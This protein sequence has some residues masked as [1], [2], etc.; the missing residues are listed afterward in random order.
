M[1]SAGGAEHLDFGKGS[2]VEVSSDDEGF[3]DSWYVATVLDVPSKK[4]RRKRE[5]EK[6]TRQNK[7]MYLVEYET[8]LANDD[9][10]ELLREYVDLSFIRPLPPTDDGDGQQTSLEVND[11][12]D[13]FHR[14]G[15]WTGVITRSVINVDHNQESRFVVL[16]Q[17]PLDEV[18]FARSELRVHHD[19]ING[20]WVRPEKQVSEQSKVVLQSNQ[21][22]LSKI[23]RRPK[24]Q[25]KS[26]RGSAM[27]FQC[28]RRGKTYGV[29][30]ANC[31]S[32]DAE[33][34]S[35]EMSVDDRPLLMW[36]KGKDCPTTLVDSR[37]FLGKAVNQLAE[38]S[39]RPNE[40][41]MQSPAISYTA[42]VSKKNTKLPF[43]KCSPIW[44]VVADMEVFKKIPQEPHFCPLYEAKVDNREGLAI[45]M[46]VT[47]ANV[48]ERTSKLQFSDP[49]SLIHCS[50]E[51]LCDLE[52]HGFDVDPIRSRLN[53]L[54][55]KRERQEQLL[56]ESKGV[57]MKI[58]EHS[59]EKSIIDEEI[60]EINKKMKELQENLAFAKS[61]MDMKDVHY[62]LV[63]HQQSPPPFAPLS[64]RAATIVYSPPLSLVVDDLHHLSLVPATS[65]VATTNRTIATFYW[66]HRAC[67]ILHRHRE[68]DLRQAQPSLRSSVVAVA[69]HLRLRHRPLPSLASPLPQ[70]QTPA[71]PPSCPRNQ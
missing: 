15:W 59:L 55:S 7:Y 13:A 34:I 11:L 20:N 58:T 16:F 43:I 56:E 17:N 30:E 32:K 48:V 46:M 51:T 8:L 1:G 19:W 61:R 37:V 53:E 50:L 35:D 66:R 65:K 44:D 4:R 27:D 68:V 63:C 36:F 67:S 57:Q 29:V 62:R 2:K 18:E 64:P 49:R 14:D 70:T 21:E 25:V 54:L 31:T 60:C 10:L 47:F 42:N 28:A 22:L 38:A 9:T 12:V 33:A 24:L 5:R 41:A 40:N 71:S 6:S 69:I 45:G 26:S 39:S 3:R 52:I 23:K